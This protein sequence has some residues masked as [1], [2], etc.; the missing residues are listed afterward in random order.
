MLAVPG[1]GTEDS[2][3]VT[4]DSDLQQSLSLCWTLLPAVSSLTVMPQLT[5]PTTDTLR[6]GRHS[7][8]VEPEIPGPLTSSGPAHQSPWRVQ[9]QFNIKFSLVSASCYSDLKQQAGPGV[10]DFKFASRHFLPLHHPAAAHVRQC[11]FEKFLPL[12]EV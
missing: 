5:C 6:P 8:Q 1:P 3:T 11:C 10:S 2:V 4:S 7:F 9:G 12:I